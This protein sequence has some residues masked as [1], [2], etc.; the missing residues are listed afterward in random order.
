MSS[1]KV[2]Q[3]GGGLSVCPECGCRDLFIR[4]DFPQKAGLA[5]VALAGTAFLVLSARPRTFYIGVWVL[6]AA[7]LV[8]AL[9]YFVVRK[10]TV[11]Y[12][13]RAEFREAPINPEHRG[14][15][16]AVAEK[17]RGAGGG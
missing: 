11:C 8:D 2:S 16:L 6:V 15:E 13:C 9:L 5:V 7:T 12:R 4:K 3:P 17:Y 14:F 10:I 1:P